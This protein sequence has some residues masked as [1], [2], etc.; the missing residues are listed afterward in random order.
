M[1]KSFIIGGGEGCSLHADSPTPNGSRNIKAFF[2][3]FPLSQNCIYAF[4]NLNAC[5]HWLLSM[6][7]IHHKI[8]KGSIARADSTLPMSSV[9]QPNASRISFTVFFASSL[10]PQINMLGLPPANFGLYMN[11]FPTL[12]KDF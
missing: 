8:H 2:S 6:P 10:F 11:T 4:S 9:S 3:P 12:L 1:T 7:G 5:D